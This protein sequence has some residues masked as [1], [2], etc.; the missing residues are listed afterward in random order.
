MIITKVETILPEEDALRFTDNTEIR[1]FTKEDD[2]EIEVTILTYVNGIESQVC[3]SETIGDL[4]DRYIRR[5]RM[6][7][8]D[9][10]YD[11]DAQ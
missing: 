7:V 1:L 5:M 3:I 4:V 10:D 2:L 11:V 8:H 6:H 9:G